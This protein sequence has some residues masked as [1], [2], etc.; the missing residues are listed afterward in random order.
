M[1]GSFPPAVVY[2][3]YGR[4]A[5]GWRGQLLPFIDQEKLCKQYRFDEPRNGPHNIA[6]QDRMP[7]VFLAPGAIEALQLITG[8]QN[9]T[10]GAFELV[11]QLC[12]CGVPGCGL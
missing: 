5:Q 10:G 3:K 12:S 6:L 11:A 8:S 4:A 7:P 1:D 9:A 2:D